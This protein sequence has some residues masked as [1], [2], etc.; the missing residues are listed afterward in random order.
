M[1]FSFVLIWQSPQRTVSDSQSSP[2]CFLFRG[3]HKL[4]L[5]LVHTCCIPITYSCRVSFQWES[6]AKYEI[7]V[8]ACQV[9]LFH[10]TLTQINS[11]MNC[12]AKNQSSESQKPD[13]RRRGENLNATSITDKHGRL[14]RSRN[15]N[16]WNVR[17]MLVEKY[18]FYLA[19][20]NIGHCRK[21]KQMRLWA[22]FNAGPKFTR[23]PGMVGCRIIH[24]IPQTC[25]LFLP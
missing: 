21:F 11:E 14:A 15:R 23:L 3:C 20:N 6:M 12:I 16:K 1:V 13:T 5:I 19:F 18:T 25:I 17:R 22:D 9:G 24:M 10:L 8:L 2:S 4:I 7:M